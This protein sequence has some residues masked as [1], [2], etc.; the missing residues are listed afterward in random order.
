[1]ELNQILKEFISGGW[2]VTLVGAIGM[3]ARLLVG[4][5]KIGCVEQFKRIAAAAM[6][7]TIAWFILEQMTVSSLTKAISYGI[8]GVISPELI[9]GIIKLAKKFSNKPEQ[10]VKKD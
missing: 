8:V 5:E 1:M 2:I 4:K 7:S 3:A 9:S 10:F 6:C